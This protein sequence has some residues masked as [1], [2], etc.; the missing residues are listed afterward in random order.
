[1]RV[2]SNRSVRVIQQDPKTELKTRGKGENKKG[3]RGKNKNIFKKQIKK[4]IQYIR[5]KY[6]NGGLV[7]S[8]C[9]CHSTRPKNRVK[10]QGK[11]WIQKGELKTRER[12]AP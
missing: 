11:R 4:N 10:N 8:K 3:G 9:A 12:P 7:E 5:T 6:K 2:L 1:M